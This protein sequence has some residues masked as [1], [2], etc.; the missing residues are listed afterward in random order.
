MPHSV[1]EPQR[2]FT[3]IE[4]L[5]VIA[6]IAVLIGLTLGAVQSV[7]EAAKRTDCMNRLK[8]QGLAVL[9]YESIN[10]YLPPGA[11]WGPFP[12]LGVAEDAGVGLWAFLLPEL[13]QDNIARLYRF[14]LSYDD[15]GNQSAATTHIATLMCPNLDPNRVE[16]WDPPPLRSRGRLCPAGRE[17]LPRG[18]RP[19]RP[20]RELCRPAA[21]KRYSAAA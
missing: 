11:V 19:D 2:G 8:N 1:R 20:G 14:D 10:G 3:L 6:I 15:P 21:A 13:E 16:L 4:L 18:S 7:R 5:L 9:N 17:P 12:S